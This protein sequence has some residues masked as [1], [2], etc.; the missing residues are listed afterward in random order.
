MISAVTMYL[1]TI[2]TLK[3][4]YENV[5]VV[6]LIRNVI[7]ILNFRKTS[8]VLNPKEILIILNNFN[9]KR[10]IKKSIW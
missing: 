7:D 6:L 10:I 1:I 8:S 2:I 4:K 9:S 3:I 5:T